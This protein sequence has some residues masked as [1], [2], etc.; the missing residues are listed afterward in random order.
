MR[1]VGALVAGIGAFIRTYVVSIL[2]ADRGGATSGSPPTA[3]LA[4]IIELL[5]ASAVGGIVFALVALTGR[6]NRRRGPATR[7][8]EG[9]WRWSR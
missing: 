5:A 1:I 8:E 4:F 3:G 7:D 9:R 2:A 6:R